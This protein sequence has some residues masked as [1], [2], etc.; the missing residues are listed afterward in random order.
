MIKTLN[1]L[2][3][4]GNLIPTAN[5][6][7]N[8]KRLHTFPL[9]TGIRQLC[10]F[11]PLLFNIILEVLAWEISQEKEIQGINI[12][13]EELKLCLF[14]DYMVLYIENPKEFKTSY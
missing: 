9:R 11:L 5:A 4:E 8:G 6:I 12:G 1:K 7:L 14:T 13:N 2:K 10:L 3:I